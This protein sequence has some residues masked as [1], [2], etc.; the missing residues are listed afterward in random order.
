M[1][2]LAFFDIDGT[3]IPEGQ[4]Q[5]PKNTLNA[6]HELMDNGI[7]VFVCTGR[8]YH[9]AKHVIDAIGTNNYICSNGQEVCVNGEILYQNTFTPMDVREAVDIFER[10]GVN[11]GFE[12]RESLCIPNV[13]TADATRKL[14]EAYNFD[15]IKS[16]IDPL[17][18]NIYQ[19]W[20][21][22][23]GTKIDELLEVIVNKSFTY[24][25]WREDLFEILPGVESKA[26]GIS[27]VEEYI[28]G[29]K[30][31]YGFGDGVNDLEMMK[32]VDHSVAMGNA[33]QVLKDECEYTTTNSEDNGIVN[34]L[35]LVG[36]LA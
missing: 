30:T 33:L 22:G 25:K 19:F 35:R 5:V 26:K 17:N 16:D 28:S 36:L 34:G 18:C 3:L 32:H 24:Y 1:Q 20:I 31:T 10:Y 2:K 29:P 6:L 9:Q 15:N 4:T 23:S 11:W 8:C 14:L 12:T 13:K 7:V 21:N 27:I